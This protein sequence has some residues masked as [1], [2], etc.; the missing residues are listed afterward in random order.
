MVGTANLE[1]AGG[2]TEKVLSL[3]NESDTSKSDIS[4]GQRT[5][6]Y[7]AAN[8]ISFVYIKK[9]VRN[10]SGISYS[11]HKVYVGE[12]VTIAGYYKNKFETR[13]ARIVGSNVPLV[14]GNAQLNENLILDI[15]LKP[16]T[17]GSAVFDQQG[18]LLG[19]IVLS[20]VLKAGGSDVTASIALPVETIAKA[21]LKLD[22]VL[23][24]TIFRYVPE[25]EE[26]KSVQTPAELSQESDAP[27][28]VVEVIP[29]LTAVPSEVPNPVGKL[30]FKAEAASTLMVNFVTKQCLVQGTQKSICHELS[31]VD[32]QQTFRK[33][34]KNGRLGEPTEFFPVLGHGVW[35]QTGWTDSLGTI[36]ANPWIFQGSMDD[37]YLFSFR[38]AAKDA[39]C[40]FVEYSRGTRLFGGGYPTWKG[41]VAC[42]EQI[43]TDKDFNVLSV[44]TEILPPEGCLTQVVQMAIYY[45]WVKL[46]ELK[47]P[48]LVPV[49]EKITAKMLG[50]K[51]LSYA[52]VSWT[53]YQ[54]FRAEHKIR[55]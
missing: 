7:N 17:S 50:Q 9:P 12:K 26:P 2:H 42:F 31:I 55:F 29:Q 15:K 25:D 39:R 14:T 46:E 11:Y 43:V 24:A 51:S 13:E 52:S 21:L 54:K 38:S 40:Y 53:D 32:G 5:L 10:K 20:G 47:S 23:G 6:F 28:G 35:T 41:P 8:D 45:D 30:R 22:P 49:R 16:G 27:G 19:M 37:R 4:V 1:V 48:S 3:A 36:A 44:F 34:H 33:I 18:N